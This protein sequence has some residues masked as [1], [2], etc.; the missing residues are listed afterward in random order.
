MNEK[1]LNKLTWNLKD[2]LLT[3]SPK[4]V[5]DLQNNSVPNNPLCMKIYR[6]IKEKQIDINNPQENKEKLYKTLNSINV[7]DIIGIFI[8]HNNKLIPT[9]CTVLS[10]NNW[11]T[12]INGVPQTV[13]ISKQILQLNV[14]VYGVKRGG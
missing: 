6:E 5:I 9:I 7:N 1:Y 10:K 8:P 14:N 4:N 12:T 11:L 3:F 2:I 13:K